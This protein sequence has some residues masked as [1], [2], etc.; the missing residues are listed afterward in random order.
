MLLYSLVAVF[1]LSLTCTVILADDGLLRTSTG[2]TGPLSS[3]T[4]YVVR[5]NVTVIATGKIEI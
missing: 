5:L 2:C 4:M 3:S 1:S